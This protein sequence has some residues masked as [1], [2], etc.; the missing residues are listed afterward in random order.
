MMARSK[1]TQKA[2]SPL[3]VSPDES[4]FSLAGPFVKKRTSTTATPTHPQ[5]QS[6]KNM[7]VI[8]THTDIDVDGMGNLVYYNINQQYKYQ[9][10]F[11][12]CVQCER[13]YN[14]SLIRIFKRKLLNHVDCSLF[15]AQQ[16]VTL[17]NIEIQIK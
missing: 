7:K 8:L 17:S 6:L 13:R 12:W 14:H 4:I 3:C 10:I 1:L 16:Y 15:F 5:Q 9:S 2:V 11:F